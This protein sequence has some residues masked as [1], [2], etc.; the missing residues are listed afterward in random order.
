MNKKLITLAVA[1]A[2]VL[3]N[4]VL[5]EEAAPASPLSFNVGVV[6]DYLFRGI[7]QTHH[8]PALQGGVDYAFSN[9]FYVGAW[10]S[11]ITWVKD[12]IGKGSTELD[13]YGGYKGSINEDVGYDIGYITYNYPSKG[14]AIPTVLANPNT[15]ELHF[16]MNYKWLS[17]K[18]SYTTSEHFV[19]WYGGPLLNQNTRGSNY[20]EVNANYDLGDGWTL[21]GHA[22]HQ[23]VKSLG[24]A[25]Y[26]DWNFGASKDVGFG[27][28]S[29]IYSD[30]NAKGSCSPVEAY[31]WTKFDGSSPK[32]VSKGTAVLSFVKTF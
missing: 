29:L 2:V 24:A 7:S 1:G 8:K 10:A 14:A 5:A 23:K 4:V 32:N 27:T 3:P 25:S 31:C 21:L 22:G 18:D 26:T 17:F 11:T 16:G 15:Q 13:V 12:W 20:F 9:G 30:T 6:S 19:G 28:V